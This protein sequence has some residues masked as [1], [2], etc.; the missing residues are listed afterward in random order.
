MYSKRQ[1]NKPRPVDE[2][3]M[4]TIFRQTK[5]EQAK[6]EKAFEEEQQ[7]EAI[8]SGM[9]SK[10]NYQSKKLTD[11]LINGSTKGKG[12]KR[13]VAGSTV[14]VISGTFSEFEGILKKVNHRTGKVCDTIPERSR[15]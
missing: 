13:L 1:I 3:D 4:E 9:D 6:S 8:N 12:K 5:E 10:P 7:Q 2:V 11:P 14:R 15:V